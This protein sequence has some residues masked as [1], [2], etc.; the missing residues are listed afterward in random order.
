[1]EGEWP[2]YLTSTCYFEIKTSTESLLSQ[3]CLVLQHISLNTEY[4]T[5]ISYTAHVSKSTTMIQSLGCIST[6]WLEKNKVSEGD[7]IAVSSTETLSLDHEMIL[8]HNDGSGSKSLVTYLRADFIDGQNKW[9]DQKAEGTMLLVTFNTLHFVENSDIASIS[10]SKLNGW[11]KCSQIPAE[12]FK[13]MLNSKPVSPLQEGMMS[14]H[15][16]LQHPPFHKLLILLAEKGVT[17]K[18]LASLKGRVS[19]SLCCLH[20]WCCKKASL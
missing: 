4:S 6:L 14:H 3:P 2:L 19:T 20:I 16:R 7:A 13:S 12:D 10:Q 8:V 5:Y 17:T 9:K 11:R 15:I 1:M 18:R